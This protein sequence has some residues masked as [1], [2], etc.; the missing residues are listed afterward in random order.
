MK[1]LQKIAEVEIGKKCNKSVS[2]F[3]T[4][5][6]NLWQNTFKTSCSQDQYSVLIMVN[7]ESNMC[8]ASSPGYTVNIE[9][10]E[11]NLKNIYNMGH[12]TILLQN[13]LFGNINGDK[14]S[15]KIQPNNVILYF[16]NE[17]E[18]KRYICFSCNIKRY[19]TTAKFSENSWNKRRSKFFKRRHLYVSTYTVT[20]SF[21]CST[22]IR[23]QKCYILVS[24]RILQKLIL[25]MLF[26]CSNR[27]SA[28]FLLLVEMILSFFKNLHFI[29]T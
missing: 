6:R 18:L 21:C 15:R 2:I 20:V 25:S 4:I 14:N 9:K 29:S 1:I 8:I 3:K 24:D 17:F 28:V 19:K 13:Y 23:Y 11:K 7:L 12:K 16:S 22:G 5:F 26:D 10:I 27:K